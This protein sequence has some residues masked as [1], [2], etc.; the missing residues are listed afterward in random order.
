MP[1]GLLSMV[2]GAK[3]RA[4]CLA[5]SCAPFTTPNLQDKTVHVPLRLSEALAPA[6]KLN[7]A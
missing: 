7:K 5:V 1:S 2:A 3:G 6:D 4:A